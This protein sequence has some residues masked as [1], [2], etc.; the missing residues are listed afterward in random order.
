MQFDQSNLIISDNLLRLGS[1]TPPSERIHLQA[2]PVG[3]IY[4]NGTLRSF[5]VGGT[6]VLRM[7]Y[8]AVRDP[9]WNTVI[10]AINHQHFQKLDD[11]FSI[12]FIA[13]Y[14]GYG[15]EFE[16]LISFAGEKDGSITCSME[17][18]A[19]NT[20]Q[21]NR[22]GFCVLHPVHTCMGKEVLIGHSDGTTEKGAFPVLINPHQ[23]FLEVAFMEY[24]PEKD[25]RLRIDFEGDVF[26]TEDQRNWTDASYKTYSTPLALP[27]P[28]KIDKG[29]VIEQKVRFS[30]MKISPRIQIKPLPKQPVH[31]E[32]TKHKTPFPAIGLLHSS[33]YP[34]LSGTDSSLLRSLKIDHLRVDLSFAK[35]TWQKKFE[36]ASLIAKQL[37][38]PLFISLEFSDHPVNDTGNFID[39]CFTDSPKIDSLLLINE[40]TKV[41]D[42]KWFVPVK[43]LLRKKWENISV[44]AGT[45]ANFAEFNRNRPFPKEADFLAWSVNPQ[46]HTFDY[47]TII[48]NLQ[49]QADTVIS[50]RTFQPGIPLWV[51]PVTLKPRFNSVAT[52]SETSD[53]NFLSPPDPR[54]MSLFAAGWITGSIKYLAEA[55]ASKITLC[56]T[57]GEKGLI[58][59]QENS[60]WPAEFP[61]Q[62]GMI[63]P[64]FFVLSE[65]LKYSKSLVIKT[66][67]SH[68]ESVSALLLSDGTINTLIL[69][70]HS[71]EVVKVLLPS[72]DKE[73]SVRILDL[74]FCRKKM[75][76][77]GNVPNLPAQILK[78]VKGIFEIQPFTIVFIRSTM[79]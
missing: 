39:A 13:T 45:N 23:P 71:P 14:K 18:R 25:L 26:E 61:A 6:E 2:G 70:S 19:L 49:T 65:L 79:N 64:A 10:P 59:G 4:E 36:E 7:I 32:I 48:E 47:L 68:P 16:A 27:F 31:I 69:A 58:Q 38:L 3:I 53:L 46:V 63:F 8:P 11:R 62:K 52:Q 33:R 37:D 20:F 12:E 54:Q 29:T 78:P 40:A 44:G 1:N 22:I 75:F 42:S 51:T 21:K 66:I 43:K 41:S 73:I 5:F 30:V 24:A 56:E 28:V 72:S 15:I 67:V 35:K 17:G 74:S 60:H 50:A 55:G 57:T 9:D 34:T 76:S 77:Q